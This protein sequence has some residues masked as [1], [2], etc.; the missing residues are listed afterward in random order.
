MDGGGGLAGS[1]Y[2]VGASGLELLQTSFN[3]SASAWIIDVA[4][5]KSSQ[6]AVVALYLPRTEAGP[7]GYYTAQFNNTFLPSSFPCS[8]AD[9]TARA[10][11]SCCLSDFVNRY[12]V[13]AA[14]TTANSNGTACTSPFAAPPVLIAT[15]SVSGGFGGDMPSSWAAL[16]PPV[17]G[18]PAW[19]SAV[20]ITVGRADLR[21]AASRFS[22]QAGVSE[23]MEAF[24]GLAQFVPVPGNRILDS[25]ASQIA[26]SLV[27]SDY[28]TVTTSGTDAH[29]FLSYINVRV[30]EVLDA[31][32][33]TQRSQYAA[34]SFALND[35]FSPN[36]ATGLIP[37][38]SIRVSVGSS[39]ES[40]NWT[41]SCNRAV[42]IQFAARLLQ[43]CGPSVAMCTPSPAISLTDRC[44]TH[45]LHPV[46]RARSA[47]T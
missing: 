4:F 39:K 45:L 19:V 21:S 22:G 29:T 9:I 5:T 32:D 37:A 42:P 36:A 12:H 31:A 1:P 43:S 10:A 28:F 23:A 33:P 6:D 17:P 13:A 34:V 38:A 41:S 14:F 44:D 8:S 11:T 15:D 25:S 47:H 18:Q 7:D 3:Q 16:L 20:R 30:N 46:S 24:V 26:L 27:K 40:A 2:S 35:D